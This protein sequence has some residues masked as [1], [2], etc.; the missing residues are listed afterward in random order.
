MWN[1]T[2]W[3][4]HFL[5]HIKLPFDIWYASTYASVSII[6]YNWTSN[7]WM[8]VAF[9]AI[10]SFKKSTLTARGWCY[11]Y[12]YWFCFGLLRYWGGYWWW[13]CWC[14]CCCM[15]PYFVSLPCVGPCVCVCIEF[16]GAA[17]RSIFLHRCAHWPFYLSAETMENILSNSIYIKSRT[18]VFL[19]LSSSS[20]S[21]PSPHRLI[22]LCG[23]LCCY[24]L[25]Q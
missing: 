10:K 22:I 3:Q 24:A 20:S 16:T 1:L 15:R 5:S 4:R 23:W 14:C 21:P 2:Q 7:S 18:K 13:C 17:Q 6:R 8:W 11:C 19:H 9:S 25:T 12:C